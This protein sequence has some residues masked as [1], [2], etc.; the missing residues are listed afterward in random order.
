MP[1]VILDTIYNQVGKRVRNSER[2]NRLELFE[3][4]VFYKKGTTASVDLQGVYAM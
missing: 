3:K 2:C 1:Q 4:K